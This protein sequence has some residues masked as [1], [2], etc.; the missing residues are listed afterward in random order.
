M[1]LP[2][3]DC[4]E[5]RKEK[6][7]GYLLNPVHPDGAGKA[8]LFAA[9][10]FTVEEWEVLVDAF[11]SVAA[12]FPVVKEADSPHGKKYVVD[13]SLTTPCGRM[14]MVRSVWIIDQGA[15]APRLVTAFPLEEGE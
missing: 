4:V 1:N 6:I 15:D 13:G 5:I 7:T 11:R 9:M 10:G 3:A 2:K 14:P 8:A 12:S